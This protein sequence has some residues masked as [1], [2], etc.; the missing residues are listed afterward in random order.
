MIGSHI[1][2]KFY[3]EQFAIPSKRRKARPGRIWVYQRGREPDHRATSRQG[4]E[5][6]YFEF[7]GPDGVWDESYETVL[8][9]HEGNC[10]DVLVCA[11]FD[12]FHWP[13][14]SRE[15]LA[16]Y[17][18][19]LFSRAT[20]RRRQSRSS[21]S[22]TL[23]GFK[24]AAEDERLIAELAEA[25]SRKYGTRV[26]REAIRTT[27]VE[28]AEGSY[29]PDEAHRVFLT[30]LITNADQVAGWL[31][32]KAPWRILRPPAETEFITTD[33]PL[34]TFVPLGNGILHPGYGFR[35][36]TAAAAFPLAP[37]ACLLMGRAWQVHSQLD[38]Q[39]LEG[40]TTA[41]V[42]ISDRFVYSKT[43]SRQ[44]QDAVQ[45]FG[46]SSRYGENAF[47]PLGVELPTPSQFLRKHFGLKEEQSASPLNPQPSG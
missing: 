42:S 47:M 9:E 16:F 37:D 39:S 32:K 28:M 1:I 29:N 25:T 11:K 3:L 14:G 34:I 22:K 38:L 23:A 44:V 24:E 5:K 20:Q 41:L 15:K 36:E 40:L 30:D 19:L 27:I 10:N 2:P 45:K 12:T 31:L 7:R 13:P 33:N 8:A 17:A 18:G 46:G 21:W 26:S 43:F 6:G 4:V 35:K